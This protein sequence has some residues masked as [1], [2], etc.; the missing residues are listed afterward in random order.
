MILEHRDDRGPITGGARLPEREVG[1]Q[2]AHGIGQLPASG[3]EKLIEDSAADRQLFLEILLKHLPAG[4]VNRN[5]HCGLQQKQDSDQQ[6]KKFG[7]K[8]MGRDDSGTIWDHGSMKA[9]LL[10]SDSDRVTDCGWGSTGRSGF[11]IRIV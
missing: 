1:G 7:L 11:Q 9:S 6:Q 4:D 10:C 3:G 8:I 5:Q 2:H